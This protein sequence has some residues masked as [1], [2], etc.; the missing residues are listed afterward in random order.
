MAGDWDGES[1]GTSEGA[2]DNPSRAGTT[3][4]FV[5]F[6][7]GATT[8]GAS[9]DPTTGAPVGVPIAAG[10]LSDAGQKSILGDP[11]SVCHKGEESKE[12]NGVSE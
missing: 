7:T 6:T 3:G 9:V 1:D 12:A 5:D 4:A 8:T 10:T 11:S 2:S